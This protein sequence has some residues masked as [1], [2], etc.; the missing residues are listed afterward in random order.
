MMDRLLDR[1]LP[2]SQQPEPDLATADDR[3]VVVSRLGAAAIDLFVCYVVLETPLIYLYSEFAPAAYRALGGWVVLASLLVLLPIYATYGFVCEWFYGRTPGKV[4]RGLLV[5][6]ADGR[7]CTLRAAAVRNLLRYVDLLGVPPFVVGL[8]A[9]L[10][11]DG[12]RV[13]DLA[14]DTVVVR[15]RAPEAV[16]AVVRADVDTSPGE[17]ASR[18]S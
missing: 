11:T 18:G 17:R 3:D 9:M 4:N 16:D 14:A 7:E 1:I 8:A 15:S 12:R 10:A 5:V 6:M 2:T 13:G